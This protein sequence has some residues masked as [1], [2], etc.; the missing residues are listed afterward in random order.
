M[1]ER[2]AFKKSDFGVLPK[3]TIR[4]LPPLARDMAE[5]SIAA[6]PLREMVRVVDWLT[7]LI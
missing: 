6:T 3:E 5:V 2:R 1:V 4:L 7:R